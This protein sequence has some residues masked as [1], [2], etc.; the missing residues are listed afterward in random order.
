MTNK[1]HGQ[2]GFT[3]VELLVSLAIIG[4]ILAIGVPQL[5]NA[6]QKARQKKSMADIREMA[7]A[8]EAYAIDFRNYPPAAMQSV[9]VLYGGIDYPSRTLGRTKLYVTP[10][11]L[12]VLPL[13]DGWNSWYLYNAS[14]PDYAIVSVGRDGIRSQPASGGPTTNFNTDIVYSDGQFTVYPQGAQQ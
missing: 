3:L 7:T 8:I 4:I 1:S 14:D 11:Y 9:P 12:K 10:T 13:V 6:L 5:M 2:K